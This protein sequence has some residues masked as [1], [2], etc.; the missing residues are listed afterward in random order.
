MKL[1]RRA[2]N[3]LRWTSF[4]KALFPCAWLL[5]GTAR[6]A[7]NL[8]PFRYLAR[9]LGVQFGDE[10]WSPL[11]TPEHEAAAVSVGKVVRAAAATTPW[12]SDC[13]PQAIAARILL[14]ARGVPYSLFLGVAREHGLRTS[15]HAWVTAG[16]VRVTGGESFSNF[17]VLGSFV[18]PEVAASRVR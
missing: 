4:E 16:R 15:A 3:F 8:L 17:R 11:L 13:L 12:K 9:Q 18:A 5:L 7:I 14:G 6:A 2:R 10:M 1:V